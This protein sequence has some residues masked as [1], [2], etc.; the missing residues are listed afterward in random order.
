MKRMVQE[1]SKTAQV[2]ECAYWAAIKDECVPAP[3]FRDAL[4][5]IR[6]RIYALQRAQGVLE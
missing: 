4:K 1:L 5:R 3:A 2:M 6:S